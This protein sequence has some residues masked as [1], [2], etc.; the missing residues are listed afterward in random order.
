MHRF[1]FCGIKR[2]DGAD[3]GC[4]VERLP[5]G[6]SC[7]PRFARHWVPGVRWSSCVRDDCTGAIKTAV[8]AT[9]VPPSSS[10]FYLLFQVSLHLPSEFFVQRAAP[11][12]SFPVRILH[13]AILTSR[14]PLPRHD[15][16]AFDRRFLS[17]LFGKAPSRHR[18]RWGAVGSTFLR[19]GF[20]STANNVASPH[21]YHGQRQRPKPWRTSQKWPR[22]PHHRASRRDGQVRTR[23]PTYQWCQ[24]RYQRVSRPPCSRSRG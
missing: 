23:R 10:L 8:A 3:E 14:L 2:R 20:T 16:R 13:W 5:G 1:A 11:S 19:S 4:Y 24:W 6:M 15:H 17:R 21:R 12:K 22:S 7:L 18:Y 9:L